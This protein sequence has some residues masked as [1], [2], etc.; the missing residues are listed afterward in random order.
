MNE[1]EKDRDSIL[2][3]EYVLGL[4]SQDEKDS[5]EARLDQELNL[6]YECDYWAERLVNLTDHLTPISPPEKVKKRLE[7][8]L[9]PDQEDDIKPS[10]WSRLF[11]VRALVGLAA[12]CVLV[13]G[14]WL[15]SPQGFTPNYVAQL[16][17]VQQTLMISTFYDSQT[18]QLQIKPEKGAAPAGRDY[19]LWAIVGKN[20]PVSLGVLDLHGNHVIQVPESLAG[21]LATAVLAISEEP[22]GGSP[23]GAPTGPVVA[24]SPI[25][26]I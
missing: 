1:F 14:I 26:A 23:T 11:S 10:I 21:T 12:M 17:T 8:R 25:K 5:F 3:A 20:A 24:V 18:G 4:M 7:A 15:A 13:L 22:K 2:S 16:Q 19:E 9:F 6:R